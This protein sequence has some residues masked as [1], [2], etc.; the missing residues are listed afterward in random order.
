MVERV[1]TGPGYEGVVD[2][3]ARRA[4]KDKDGDG[5]S[6]GMDRVWE[7]LNDHDKRLEKIESKLDRLIET[8]SEMKG[9][10]SASPTTW[11]LLGIMITTWAA[12]A[13]IVFALTRLSR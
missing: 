3:S 10:L 7:K 13:A 2:L 8:V 1:P 4:L 6:G 12:G 9:R 11:Q 5:T